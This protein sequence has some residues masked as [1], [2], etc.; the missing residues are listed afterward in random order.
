MSR[1]GTKK[2]TA[3]AAS[4]V[5]LLEAEV[6]DE[7]IDIE[8]NGVAL[9]VNPNAVRSGPAMRAMM[10]ENNNFWPM[11]EVLVPDPEKQAELEATLPQHEYGYDLEDFGVMFGELFEKASG[12]KA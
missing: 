8:V 12:K 1:E 2:T 5:E 9:R 7:K 4:S 10:N 3:E 6:K 11:Y